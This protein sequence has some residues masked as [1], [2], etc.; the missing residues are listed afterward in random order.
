MIRPIPP[1]DL[2]KPRRPP[3]NP[4]PTGE[5]PIPPGALVGRRT[6]LKAGNDAIF[7]SRPGPWRPPATRQPPQN[8]RPIPGDGLSKLSPR[9][10]SANFGH[11]DFRNS[12]RE[13]G[14]L[15]DS[16]ATYGDLRNLD[17]TRSRPENAPISPG[18]LRRPSQPPENPQPTAAGLVDSRN[19]W[20]SRRE[21]PPDSPGDLNDLRRTRSR[22]Q[23][24]KPRPN[25]KSPSYG[26]SHER[27]STGET[28][29]T[30][31]PFSVEPVADQ[32]T[33]TATPGNLRQPPTA[34]ENR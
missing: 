13:W 32:R 8:P 14:R 6:V 26:Q 21:L 20:N 19:S 3:E 29:S 33:A 16:P 5:R 15:P 11:R 9:V 7:G 12:R 28:I 25:R 2:R 18:D 1:G 27:G 17:R 30:I 10:E 22:P 23:R 24:G 4:E 31:S 34:A